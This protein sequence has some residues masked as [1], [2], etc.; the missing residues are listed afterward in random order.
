MSTAALKTGYKK[1][2]NKLLFF[3]ISF[4][5]FFSEQS[6]SQCTSVSIYDRI[7]SGYHSTLAVKTDGK[8]ALW[9][10]NLGFGFVNQLTPWELDPLGSATAI[11]GTI[12]GGS[13][14]GY[15]QVIVL[16][17]DGLYA[18]GYNTGEF[19]SVLPTNLT[20]STNFQKITQPLGGNS[21]GLPSGIVPDDVASIFATYKTL[22]I[23][24]KNDRLNGNPRR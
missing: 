22:L 4:L 10:E 18:L 2:F 7:V 19:G 3:V 20:P 5:F 8:I 12:G 13:D 1:Y 6:Q 11:M 15:D 23:V 21:Y 17:S 16:T 24:T 9:G 14:G